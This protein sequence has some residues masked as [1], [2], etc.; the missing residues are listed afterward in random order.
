[1][2]ECMGIDKPLVSVAVLTYGHYEGLEHTLRSVV[3]QT[4]PMVEIIV[5]DDGSGKK[6]PV[7][8][9]AQYQKKVLFLQNEINI[10]TVA[11]M[12]RVAEKLRGTYIKFIAA[13]DELSSSDALSRL[14]CCAIKENTVVTTSQSMVCDSTLR[15]R[16]YPFPRKAALRRME[17]N[18]EQQFIQLAKENCIS[19]VGTLLH[20]DFFD[21]YGGF[22]KEYRLLEDWPTWIREARCGRRIGILPEITCLYAVG[23]VSSHNVDAFASEILR[24]D[25]LH[26]YESEIMPYVG[27]LP[28]AVRHMALYRYALLHEKSDA[29]IKRFPLLHLR[30]LVKR[31]LKR[32]LI[33]A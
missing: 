26:C 20:R 15:K 17:T 4:Y 7:E 23:G 29:L 1:M 9:V 6:F 30:T 10:G 12:N 24:Q 5:S 2:N 19:A 33:K 27:R 22:S 25:M 21:L 18:P 28:H 13:D 3:A 32:W 8:I 31:G 16:L 14:V 11:H